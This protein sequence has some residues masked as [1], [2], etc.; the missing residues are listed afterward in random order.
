M[1]ISDFSNEQIVEVI[2]LYSTPYKTERETLDPIISD[3]KRDNENILVRTNQVFMG[4]MLFDRIFK[5]TDDNNGLIKTEIIEKN[6]K[7]DVYDV[8]AN[9]SPLFRMITN[10]NGDKGKDYLSRLTISDLLYFVKKYI[11]ECERIKIECNEQFVNHCKDIFLINDD[12]FIMNCG[13]ICFGDY[14]INYSKH[15]HQITKLNQF[16]LFDEGDLDFYKVIMSKLTE[17]EK[18]E[19]TKRFVDAHK[20][21]F[22]KFHSNKPEFIEKMKEG[23]RM[24]QENFSL[25]ILKEK[26][27]KR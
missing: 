20:T 24:F 19:Y 26:G 21:A 27:C 16:Y 3:I 2:N 1:Q 12:G 15:F 10:N 22:K 17:E 13:A 18:F 25:K 4:N 11:G 5:F 9:F 8:S 6:F 23:E 14:G 7:F